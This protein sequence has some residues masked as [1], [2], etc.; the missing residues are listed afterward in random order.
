MPT[1]LIVIFLEA[2]TAFLSRCDPSGNAADGETAF[3]RCGRVADDIY[4]NFRCSLKVAIAIIGLEGWL[5]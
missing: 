3:S 1:F 2:A 4:A 5:F